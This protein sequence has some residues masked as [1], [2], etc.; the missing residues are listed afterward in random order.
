MSWAVSALQS[1][2]LGNEVSFSEAGGVEIEANW[3]MVKTI[4]IP[5]GSAVD[6]GVLAP[7]FSSVPLELRPKMEKFV[8]ACLGVR[9]LTPHIMLTAKRAVHRI[10]FALLMQRNRQWGRCKMQRDS[11]CLVSG[12]TLEL[13]LEKWSSPAGRHVL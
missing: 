13:R 6:P 12:M 4:F 5:T 9:N 7:L 2:R 11:A 8:E 10:C 3:D 1:H